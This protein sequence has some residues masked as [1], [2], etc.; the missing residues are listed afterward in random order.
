MLNA[1]ATALDGVDETDL[2]DYKFA[3]HALRCLE[4]CAA[5]LNATGRPFFL[6]VGFHWP[7][8]PYNVPRSAWDKYE[9]VPFPTRAPRVPYGLPRWAVGDVQD[10]LKVM[11]PRVGTASVPKVRRR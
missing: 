6:A 3:S 11:H 10:P 1:S 2:M 7:H 4:A 5:N 8:E 9:G